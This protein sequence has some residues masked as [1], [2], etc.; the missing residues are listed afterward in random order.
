LGVIRNT[1][2]AWYGGSYVQ[3]QVFQNG[4]GRTIV[5]G[6]LGFEKK[7]IMTFYLNKIWVLWQQPIISSM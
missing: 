2:E 4:D 3:S 7:K 5:N 6:K 1:E